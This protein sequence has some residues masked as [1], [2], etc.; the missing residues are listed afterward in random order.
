MKA[1]TV[2][3]VVAP[4]IAMIPTGA[5]FAPPRVLPQRASSSSSSPPRRRMTDDDDDAPSQQDA[6]G[7]QQQDE[8]V[9]PSLENSV[10]P[11]PSTPPPPR[12]LDPLIRSLTRVDDVDAA[13]P[14]V[15]VPL[16]GELALDRSLYVFVPA[17]AFAVIG[18][19]T[20]L[21]VA[22]TATDEW[23]I[24]TRP[25]SQQRQRRVID[26]GG[27]RGLCSQQEEDLEG[28]RNYM[29]KFAKK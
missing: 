4:L 16:L 29:Q 6:K 15:R 20:S 13:S 1:F 2:L 23:V 26:D 10:I 21:Y 12:R 7:S 11:P 5:A 3:S 19:V 9:V 27:C 18:L 24:P 28:L 8:V 22:L 14:T 25:E 17:A